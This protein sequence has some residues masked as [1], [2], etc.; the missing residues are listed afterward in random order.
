MGLI[1]QNAACNISADAAHNGDEGLIRTR[2][3][4]TFLP[5][6]LDMRPSDDLVRQ[7]DEHCLLVHES[8]ED[9]VWGAPLSN[10]AWVL[11]ERLLSRKIIHFTT[12]Q[13]FFESKDSRHEANN[14]SEQWP[15]GVRSM[16]FGSRTDEVV[17]WWNKLTRTLSREQWVLWTHLVER[18]SQMR[19]KYDTD[20]LAALSGAVKETQSHTGDEYLAGL[21]EKDLPYQLLWHS[22]HPQSCHRPQSYTAPTWSWASIGSEISYRFRPKSFY[23]HRLLVKFVEA[24]ISSELGQE[25]TGVIKDALLRLRGPLR[26][27]WLSQDDH[28]TNRK[29]FWAIGGSRK[30][31]CFLPDDL[32]TG[33]TIETVDFEEDIWRLQ[34]VFSYSF[35]GTFEPRSTV[36]VHV[37]TQSVFLLPIVTGTEDF[38]L[39]DFRLREE[40][41]IVTVGLT[42]IPTDEGRGKFQR[43]G[44]FFT[45]HKS[46]LGSILHLSSVIEKCYYE[47]KDRGR[48]TISII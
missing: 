24:Q 18:Y 3:V 48:Y 20:R 21:W 30:R 8:W 43:V 46:E 16:Y 10:R 47:K 32:C 37:P 38:C 27:A 6:K 7:I 13:L 1:Y 2:D 19:L 11:Q 41:T 4:D 22:T 34:R 44:L 5:L 23:N 14:C 31:I 36:T 28:K 33:H 12:R 42:L 17:E 40:D 9:A 29:S 45:I 15:L 39:Q 25:N 26:Q 35:E